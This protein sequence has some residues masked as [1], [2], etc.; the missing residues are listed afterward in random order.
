MCAKSLQSCPTLGGSMD[1]SLPASSVW[2]AH[3][4]LLSG[5]LLP[6][7]GDLPDLGMEST[8]LMSPASAA[9]FLTTESPGAPCYKIRITWKNYSLNIK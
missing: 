7:P 8:S 1:G 4:R 9:K 2:D 6:P 5:L 3:A